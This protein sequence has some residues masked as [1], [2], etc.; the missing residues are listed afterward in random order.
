MI[1]GIGVGGVEHVRA[2]RDI[3]SAVRHGEESL[4]LYPAVNS[5]RPA[6]RPK[7]RP[8]GHKASV[9]LD[10][11]QLLDEPP[12][13]L[14]ALEIDLLLADSPYHRAALEGGWPWSCPISIWK[15]PS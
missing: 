7:P 9:G 6:S 15:W 11:V 8:A 12:E 2:T 13:A 5:R 3:D 14:T 4:D 10:L 1:G